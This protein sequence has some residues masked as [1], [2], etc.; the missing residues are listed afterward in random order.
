MTRVLYTGSFDPITKGH[1]N[2]IKQA[3]SLFDEVIVAVL[4][5]PLKSKGLFTIQERVDMISKLYNSTNNIKVVTGNGAAVDIAQLYG[6]KA[7]IRG[8]R[9]LSDYDYEVQM[10][11]MNKDISGNTIN[12]VCLFADKEYQFISS[13]FVKE[14]LN[15][16]KD[17]STYVDP[18]IA[19]MLYCK[20]EQVL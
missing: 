4:A 13:T 20:K 6:C 1:M 16:N 8:L 14:I 5:N 9:S 7:I 19:Q 10:Q 17:I 3:S 12:T 15:L 2:I 18:Y 11:Q